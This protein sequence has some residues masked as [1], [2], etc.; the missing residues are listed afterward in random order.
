MAI[1]KLQA[2][3]LLDRNSGEFRKS[4]VKPVLYQAFRN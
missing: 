2:A 3:E 4:E 1:V